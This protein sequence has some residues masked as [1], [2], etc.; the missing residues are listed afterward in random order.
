[1]QARHERLAQATLNALRTAGEARARKEREEQEAK[2]KLAAN[3]Q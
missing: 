3:K 2:E 1:M